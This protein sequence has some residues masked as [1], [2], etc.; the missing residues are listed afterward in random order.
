[1][2]R[3]DVVVVADGRQPAEANMGLAR[4][5]TEVP[6]VAAEARGQESA[7]PRTRTPAGAVADVGDLGPDKLPKVK[8]KKDKRG[9][10][11]KG[12]KA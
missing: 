3:V 11:D 1:M 9:K 6:M 7:V 5:A 2:D 8:S 12:P 10:K 4:L